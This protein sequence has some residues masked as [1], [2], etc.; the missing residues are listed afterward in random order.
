VKFHPNPEGQGVQI[1]KNKITFSQA[2]HCTY[3]IDKDISEGIYKMFEES[4][5]LLYIKINSI[6]FFSY[7]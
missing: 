6:F 7:Q 1:E 4:F 3:Y 2:S 5:F